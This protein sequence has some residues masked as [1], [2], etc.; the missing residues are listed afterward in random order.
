MELVLIGPQCIISL[1][2]PILLTHFL[3]PHNINVFNDH[4]PSVLTISML[5]TSTKI[6]IT[7]M[8]NI[9]IDIIL[10]ILN[11]K[12]EQIFHQIAKIRS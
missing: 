12:F 2:P 4:H 8:E 5:S 6:I 3:P 9:I 11:T 7:I 10:M 1:S